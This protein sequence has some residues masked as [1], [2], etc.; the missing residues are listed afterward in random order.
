MVVQ[1]YTTCMDGSNR[2]LH[3]LVCMC[4]IVLV[5]TCPNSLNTI[6]YMTYKKFTVIAEIMQ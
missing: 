3:F 2:T 5:R 4:V 1:L 6:N